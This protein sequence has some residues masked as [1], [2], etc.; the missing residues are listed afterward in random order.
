MPNLILETRGARSGQTRQAIVGYLAE[1]PDAWL[2]IASSG[3]ATWNP[4][5]L[6]NLAK[7]PEATLDFGDGRRVDVRAESVEGSD[8]DAAWKRIEARGQAVLGLPDEDR[9]PDRRPAPARAP[10]R[11]TGSRARPPVHSPAHDRG[12][13]DYYE[14]LGVERGADDA[15]IKRAFRKL[16]QQWHPDVNTEPEAQE[17]FKEINEAYQVLCDPQRRQQYDMFGRAGV[18]GGGGGPRLRRRRASAGSRTSSTPSSA[19]RWAAPRRRA[20]PQTGSDLRYDL[21]IT[22]EE[23]VLGTEKEIEF[24]VLGRCETCERHRREAGHD[25]VDLPPVQGP[26]R[27]PDDPPDDA[28]PD[29]QRRALPALPRRGQD[30]RD[31]VR[32]VPRRGPHRA[33]PDAPGHHP[34]GHRRGPPDPAVERGR[35]RAARRAAGQP[36]R[37]GPRRRRTRRSPARARSS[38]TRPTCRSPRPRSGT[39]DPR[40]DGRGRR[41]RGR[42]QARARSPAPRSGSAAAACRTCA[43]VLARRPPRDR[44]RHR[45]DE[46]DASGSASCSRQ[47]AKESGEPIAEHQGLREKLGLG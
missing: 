34:G 25:A 11:L 2:V 37:R 18:N 26:R 20:R 40:P 24:P 32:D 9:S 19:A 38:T 10:D 31:A 22:F 44:Q 23:A 46:A 29:G 35:G 28:R 43:G 4:A 14:V 36:L 27:G 41:H 5:W 17:R 45:P 30:R 16:A 8:L 13:R 39:Q 15:A 6:H 1:P 33:P 47:F 21:R 3:G 7:D 12:E 42:D